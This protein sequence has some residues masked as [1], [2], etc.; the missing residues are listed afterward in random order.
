MQNIAII[1]CESQSASTA[2][3]RI[4]S[5]SGILVN[6]D[7][8]LLDKFEL[9]CSNVPGYIPDPYALWVNQ[10][11]KKL[12]E[13]NMSHLALM[14]ELHKYIRKWSPWPNSPNGCVWASWNGIGFDYP[15]IQKENYK[16]LLP[17]Y[18]T[19]TGG[20]HHSDFLPVARAAKLLIPDCLE[21]NYSM[22]GNPI[23]KL[24]NLGPKNFPEL[25]QNLFHTATQDCAVTLK[26]MQKLKDKAKPIYDAAMET[27]S[28]KNAENLILNTKIFTTVFYYFGKARPFAVC[29]FFTHKI[30]QWPMVYCLENDPRDLMALDYKSLKETMKRPGKFVRALPLKHPLVLDIAYALKMEPYKTIKLETLM[31]RADMLRDNPKFAE[32]CSQAVAEIAEEKTI[33]KDSGRNLEVQL[34]PHNQLYS[35]GFP[36]QPDQEIMK[37]FHSTNN[38]EER[39][40]LVLSLSDNRFKYFGLRLIYQNQPD[41][42]P[43]NEYLKIHVD[44]ARRVLSL[45]EENYTTIPQAETLID[46]IRAEKDITK[47]KLDYMNEV[48]QMIKE[49]R[50]TY[51]KA[52]IDSVKAQKKGEVA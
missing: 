38:W 47:E 46:T 35:G 4:I 26:I 27:A 37:K 20:S 52:L 7:L 25:N 17:I 36:S 31:A 43:R 50:I 39:Y 3:A 23:F 30:Y 5:I 1:D 15:L 9:F 22:K 42:L 14:T 48:D 11:L 29:N 16:S 28:K 12:K 6:S 40:K 44:A 24:D 21:T 32:N 34:D 33:Q 18:I 41:A 10:G 2:T 8:Q 45:K 13:S 19:N 49:M 51:E